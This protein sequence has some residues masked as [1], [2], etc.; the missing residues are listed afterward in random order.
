MRKLGLLALVVAATLGFSAI[1]H[2]YSQAT[3]G[4]EIV[5]NPLGTNL[6]N[7]TMEMNGRTMNSS[8]TLSRTTTGLSGTW[9]GRGQTGPLDNVSFD[10]KTLTFARSMGQR[11][12][13]FTGTVKGDT[14]TGSYR[15][16]T[17]GA[18]REIVC[19]GTKER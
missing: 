8:M 17:G 5:L 10:G 1:G 7:M 3:S 6:W 11:S 16:G 18:A 2:A 13:N 9:S 4:V 19:N 14:I 12:L 15:G